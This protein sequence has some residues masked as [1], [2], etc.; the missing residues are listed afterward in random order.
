MMMTGDGRAETVRGMRLSG[1]FLAGMLTTMVFVDVTK[2]MVGRLRPVFLEVC[3]VNRTICFTD[4]QR[5]D[6]DHVC[7][8]SDAEMLRWAT[9]VRPNCSSREPLLLNKWATVW[10]IRGKTGNV[11]QCP[12]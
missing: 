8:Q 9:Y 2:L 5:C 1:T 7:M 11:G 4:G 12:T 6:V 3:E 10:R